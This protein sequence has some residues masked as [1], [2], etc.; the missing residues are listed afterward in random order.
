MTKPKLAL[1]AL[2]TLAAIL[3]YWIATSSN[4][5]GPSEKRVLA[6]LPLSGPSGDLGL[7]VKNGMEIAIS[8]FNA[9]HD[10]NFDILFE[11]T[12]GDANVARD[13]YQQ[14][15]N[16]SAVNH[17]AVLSWMSSAANSLRPLTREDRTV[18]F[19]GAAVPGITSSD[20]LVVRVWPVA[21]YIGDMMADEV[22]KV[23]HRK[24]CIVHVNDDYGLSVARA[25]KTNFEEHGGQVVLMEAA[26]ST[27]TDFRSLVEKI[28]AIEPDAIYSPAYGNIYTKL[29]KYIREADLSGIDLY[30]DITLLSKFTLR[31]M[32]NAADGV[33]VP[34]LNVDLGAAGT[35]DP[36]ALDFIRKHQAR[37]GFEPDFNAALGYTMVDVCLQALTNDS[38]QPVEDRIRNRKFQTPFGFI[39]FT[40]D[41]DCD[42][43]LILTQIENGKV[44]S[45]N[46]KQKELIK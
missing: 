31:E 14:Y 44:R 26:S 4:K 2:I 30:A 38:K 41:N 5:D 19:A 46:P 22:A 6:I 1:F 37:F 33:I 23:G 39:G 17:D 40:S 7:S 21:K 10:S 8:D 9:S 35:T 15:R 45:V 24:V 25:F 11:D 28:L 18:L 34:A 42:I 12:K 3:V 32:G 36:Q 16:D 13:I 20:G 43:E 29:L 27:D